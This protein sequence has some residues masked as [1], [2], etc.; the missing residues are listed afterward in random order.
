MQVVVP[1]H[2][3]PHAGEHGDAVVVHGLDADV[4]ISRRLVELQRDVRAARAAS[5]HHRHLVLERVRRPAVA[6]HWQIQLSTL[7]C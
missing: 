5:D 1:G 4:H 6:D 7:M 3:L 2:S